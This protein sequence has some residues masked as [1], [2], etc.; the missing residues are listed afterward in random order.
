M[1]YKRGN[2]GIEIMRPLYVDV[3]SGRWD[4]DIRSSKDQWVFR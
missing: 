2:D 4:L 1:K 3:V